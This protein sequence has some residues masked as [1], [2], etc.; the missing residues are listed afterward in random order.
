MIADYPHVPARLAP[1][2]AQWDYMAE[3]LLGRLDG[4]D[5]AE[6]LWQPAQRVWTVQA[7]SD[8]RSLPDEQSW[9]PGPDANPP[10]TIAWSVGHLA[11][12]CL[13]RADHLVGSH[14]LRDEDLDWPMTAKAGLASLR[15]GL[16]AWRSGLEQMGDVDLD[17][18]GRSAYPEGMDP[19]LPLMDI[20]WWVNKELLEHAAEIWYVRDLYAVTVPG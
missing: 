4:I 17:T 1:F 2:L 19:S 20:V 13:I 6:Y 11:A 10:R 12:G 16:G 8:G 9:A 7:R 15:A 18:V 3:Q 5:D 14:T